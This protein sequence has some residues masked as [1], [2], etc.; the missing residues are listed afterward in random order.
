M[1]RN[2]KLASEE[3][4]CVSHSGP[5]VTE[6]SESAGQPASVTVQTRRPGMTHN[7]AC[8]EAHTVTPSPFFFV[9]VSLSASGLRVPAEREQEIV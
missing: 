6:G 2:I 5:R 7:P 9:F 1:H 3:L 4:P 8:S